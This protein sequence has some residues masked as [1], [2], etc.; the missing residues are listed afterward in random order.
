MKKIL[1]RIIKSFLM[2]K[3]YE[4]KNRNNPAYV[5]EYDEYHCSKSYK[6]KYFKKSKKKKKKKKKDYKYM[7]KKMFD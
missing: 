6:P 7:L 2:K 4:Y 5:Y 3:V 1:K